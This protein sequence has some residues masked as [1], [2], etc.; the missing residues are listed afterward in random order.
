MDAGHLRPTAQPCLYP[1]AKPGGAVRGPAPGLRDLLLPG[2]HWYSAVRLA[3]LA[4]IECA[5]KQDDG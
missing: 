4:N 2:L 3:G 5:K 1:R